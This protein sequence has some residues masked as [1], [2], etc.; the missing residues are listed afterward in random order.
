MYIS[1]VLI[2][3]QDKNEVAV[4]TNHAKKM[5]EPWGSI[6]FRRRKYQRDYVSSC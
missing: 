4:L 2:L 1:N 5:Y 3:K 6:K